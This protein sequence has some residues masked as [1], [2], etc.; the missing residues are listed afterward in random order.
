[1]YVYVCVII[2]ERR[3]SCINVV[4]FIHTT[5]YTLHRERSLSPL[6]WKKGS[7]FVGGISYIPDY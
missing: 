7:G 3:I 5:V 4:H 6:P 2:N 1:V